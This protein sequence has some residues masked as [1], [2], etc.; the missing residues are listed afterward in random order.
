MTPRYLNYKEAARYLSI[1]LTAFERDVAPKLPRFKPTAR[2]VVFL[3]DHLDAFMRSRVLDPPRPANDNA[4]ES[5]EPEGDPPPS[6]R[7]SPL[8]DQEPFHHGT[9]P[10]EKPASEPARLPPTTR[11][12]RRSSVSEAVASNPAAQALLRKLQGGSHGE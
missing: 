5:E 4:F 12:A 7:P 11:R 2:R 3:V 6:R 8:T 1:S 9:Q 10:L